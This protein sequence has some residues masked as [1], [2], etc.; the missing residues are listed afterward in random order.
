[1][2]FTVLTLF[3]ELVNAFFEHGM[4][5]RGIEKNLISGQCIH[6]RDFSF[7]RHN[8]VDDRHATVN[9]FEVY[10]RRPRRGDILAQWRS[11]PKSVSR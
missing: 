1:M 7:D 5:F 3:P 8:T 10:L 9:A 6:I 2:D 11:F 4:I